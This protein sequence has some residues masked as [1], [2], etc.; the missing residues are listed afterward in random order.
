MKKYNYESF[1][2]ILYRIEKFERDI[3]KIR[4]DISE[5]KNIKQEILKEF[6]EVKERIF[7]IMNK[8]KELDNIEKLVGYLY[9]EDVD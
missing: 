4:E 8:Y 6:D 1:L 9:I 2:D 7:N 5:L 3:K